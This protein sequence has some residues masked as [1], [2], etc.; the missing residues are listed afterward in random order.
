MYSRA[1]DPILQFSGRHKDVREGGP[2][3]VEQAGEGMDGINMVVPWPV[4][5]R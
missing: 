4:L 3:G 2:G 5:T 1:I